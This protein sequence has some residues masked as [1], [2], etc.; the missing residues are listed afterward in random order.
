MVELT[1]A[2]DT[3]NLYVR[4]MDRLWGLKSTLTIPLAHI[5][6]VRIDPEVAGG[7]SGGLRMP[8]TSI[9]E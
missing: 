6:G 5:A 1:I 3:L 2:D 8:G 9:P 4:G 7:G